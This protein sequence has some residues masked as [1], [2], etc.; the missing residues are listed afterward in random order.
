MPNASWQLYRTNDVGEWG[1]VAHFETLPAATRRIIEIE[2]I[3]ARELIFQIHVGA[4][5]TSDD[6][7]LDH[8]EYLGKHSDYVIKRQGQ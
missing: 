1:L 5:G 2:A 8:L 4:D 7:A 3:P 6:E